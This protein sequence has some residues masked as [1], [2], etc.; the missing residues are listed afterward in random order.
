MA[1]LK[2]SSALAPVTE[3]CCSDLHRAD[4]EERVETHLEKGKGHAGHWTLTLR[5]PVIKANG[6]LVQ[7]KPSFLLC[8]PTGLAF[9]N[10]S[11]AAMGLTGELFP[12]QGGREKEARFLVPSKVIKDTP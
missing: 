3:A 1:G 9:Q 5:T 6:S 12:W 11:Q 7:C 8:H 10:S 4:Q 2:F